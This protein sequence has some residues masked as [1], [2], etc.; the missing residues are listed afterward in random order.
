M[1][2]KIDDINY[3]ISDHE[4]VLIVDLIGVRFTSNLSVGILQHEAQQLHVDV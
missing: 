3:C 2:T 4:K 1:I